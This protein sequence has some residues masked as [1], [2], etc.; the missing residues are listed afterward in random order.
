MEYDDWL[1]DGSIWKL[2]RLLTYY[3]PN[4]RQSSNLKV[5]ID[6][7]RDEEGGEGE[8]DEI[9]NLSNFALGIIQIIA[10]PFAISTIYN[11]GKLEQ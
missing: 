5:K 2:K 6:L 4:F 8:R 11:S 9:S 7:K 1:L 10:L 3:F